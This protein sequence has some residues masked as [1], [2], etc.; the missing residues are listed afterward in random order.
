MSLLHDSI[1]IFWGPL[2]SKSID[3]ITKFYIC[4]EY[5]SL[6][7]VA[8][9]G[10]FLFY[11]NTDRGWICD[12]FV[13]FDVN[14]L[15]EIEIDYNGNYQLK[16]AITELPF[17]VSWQCC[18]QISRLYLL[19]KFH[20]KSLVPNLSKTSPGHRY[21]LLIEYLV[22]KQKTSATHCVDIVPKNWIHA[23][24]G[25]CCN[26]KKII[27]FVLACLNLI[28]PIFYYI[29]EKPCSSM[30]KSCMCSEFAWS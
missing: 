11:C 21:S 24:S 25:H 16:E 6:M 22:D 19:D 14:W 20:I 27:K 18:E 9:V 7:C 1:S 2:P 3:N 15:Y 30:W 5:L 29:T 13:T 23:L 12:L 28:V 26:L 10:C 17:F 8:T 4:P